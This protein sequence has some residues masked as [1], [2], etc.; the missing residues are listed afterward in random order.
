[1]DEAVFRRE[2][3]VIA[4]IAPHPNVLNIA[5]LC[6]D[7]QSPQPTVEDASLKLGKL[8]IVTPYMA[9]GGLAPYASEIAK[10]GKPEALPDAN[11]DVDLLFARHT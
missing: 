9:N 6:D 10:I 2:V 8:A 5:A 3:D 11:F 7:F 4:K 1:M